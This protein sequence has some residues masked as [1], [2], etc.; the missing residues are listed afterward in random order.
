MS[1]NDDKK[2]YTEEPW[3]ETYIDCFE[4]DVENESWA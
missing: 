4:D 1:V 3:D 2:N